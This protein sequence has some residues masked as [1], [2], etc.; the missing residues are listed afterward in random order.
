MQSL[1]HYGQGLFKVYDHLPIKKSFNPSK[2]KS[3]N[4]SVNRTYKMLLNAFLRYLWNRMR[5]WF[6]TDYNRCY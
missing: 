5:V 4:L 3:I 2:D 1:Q 6:E